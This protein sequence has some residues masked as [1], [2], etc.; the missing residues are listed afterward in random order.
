MLSTIFRYFPEEFLDYYPEDVL[1]VPDN[2]NCPTNMPDLAWEIPP[3]FRQF[4]DCSPEALGIPNLGDINVT[5]PDWKT[6]ELRRAYYAAT[7]YADHELGKV[8]DALYEYGVEN[9]TIIV[10]WGDHGWQLGEHAEWCKQNLFEITNRVPF[11]MRIP[12]VTDSGMKTSKLVELVDIFP[13]LVEAA[14]FEPLESCP[15]GLPSKDVK[16]C[17]EG[18]SMLPLFANPE[19]TIWDD[20]VFWQYSRGWFHDTVVP[21]QM[22]YSIRTADF[23]YTEYVNIKD[24]GDYKWEPE[25]NNPADHEELYDLRNDPQENVNM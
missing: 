12:G 4:T 15:V 21:N 1:D 9:D 14:G 6:K 7:S 3:I 13:T 8:I 18:R 19:T 17:T 23:R 11:M 20:T 5:L 10:F 24:L 16:L 2:P 25:W 22:G